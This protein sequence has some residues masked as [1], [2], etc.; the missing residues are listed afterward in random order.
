MRLTL[1]IPV[2][3]VKDTGFKMTSV[4]SAIHYSYLYCHDQIELALAT[5]MTRGLPVTSVLT[6]FG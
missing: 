6:A 2:N 1:R 3:N 5:T 4:A